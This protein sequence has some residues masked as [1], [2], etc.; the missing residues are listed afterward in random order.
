[1]GNIKNKWVL[2]EEKGKFPGFERHPPDPENEAG[3]KNCNKI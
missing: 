3:N 1:M 2:F